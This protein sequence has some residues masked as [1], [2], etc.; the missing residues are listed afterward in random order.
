MPAYWVR[1]RK[2]NDPVEYKKY[3]DFWFRPFSQIRGKFGERRAPSDHGGP[4]EVQRFVGWTSR[5]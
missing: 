2:I 4:A 3:T 5:L 1:A